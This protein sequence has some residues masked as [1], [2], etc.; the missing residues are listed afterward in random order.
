MR[1]NEEKYILLMGVRMIYHPIIMIYLSTKRSPLWGKL[2]PDP[3]VGHKRMRKYQPLGLS[4]FLNGTFASPFLFQKRTQNWI[5]QSTTARKLPTNSQPRVFLL[6]TKVMEF[7]FN[8]T[9]KLTNVNHVES[10][11]IRLKFLFNWLLSFPIAQ[12][13]YSA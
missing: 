2:N 8:P 7:F 12:R 3:E 9:Q 6:Q 1:K 13:F 11:F 5:L 10:D 4:L